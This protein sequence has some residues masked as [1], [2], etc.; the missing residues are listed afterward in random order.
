MPT[1]ATAVVATAAAAAAAAA[2]LADVVVGYD[3][4]LV[5]MA[6]VGP[7]HLQVVVCAC[8]TV[9]AVASPGAACRGRKKLLFGTADMLILQCELGYNNAWAL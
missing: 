3:K 9:A 6:S 5:G 2:G 7:T 4:M 8:S 1:A